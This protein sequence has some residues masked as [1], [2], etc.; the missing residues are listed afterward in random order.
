MNGREQLRG[1]RKAI[2]RRTAGSER[3]RTVMGRNW[4]G[5]PAVLNSSLA[6]PSRP[7]PFALLCAAA[8]FAILSAAQTGPGI[9]RNDFTPPQGA[10]FGRG[11]P[12]DGAQQKRLM[13]AVSTA[14]RSRNQTL[15]AFPIS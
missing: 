9:L 5:V 1:R 12:D 11:Q 2:P 4:L 10:Q 13:T 14:R 8:A 7:T 3:T 15:M 6:A